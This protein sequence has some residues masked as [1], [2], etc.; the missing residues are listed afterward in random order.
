[1]GATDA[2]TVGQL[3]SGLSGLS[4]RI[5]GLGGQVNRLSHDADAGTAGAMAAAGL[6]QAFAPG[7][8]MVAVA[9]GTWRGETA[10]A[11]GA[12]KV[13]DRQVF[14]AGASFDSRGNGGVNAGVGWQF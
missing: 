11:V 4:G 1:M 2:A 10:F 9:V 5:D 12:S 7:K 6:P 13:F 3:Q 14:K 8:G